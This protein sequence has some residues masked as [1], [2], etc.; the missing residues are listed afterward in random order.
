M[1]TKVSELKIMI[2]DWNAVDLHMHTF[3]G[4][5]GDGKPDV[6]KNF[7]YT[8]YIN[9]LSECKIKL[10]AITNHNIIN[11][12]NYIMCRY[13]AKKRG[14]NILFGVEI[15]TNRET[16]ENYHL[17]AIFEE[18]IDKCINIAKWINDKTN[19]KKKTKNQVRYSP[20]E[21][22]EL[23][24]K[25]NV[26]IIPHGEKSKGLF[27]YATEEQI[28]DALK[29]VREGFIRVFDSPSDWKLERIKELIKDGTINDVEDEFG[30]VLFSDNRDWKN[31]KAN[32]RNFYMNAEPT[33]KGFL[34]SIT[35][36]TQRFSVGNLIP[37]K[38]QY[39]SKIEIRKNEPDA[40]IDDCDIYLNSGYNCI[41]G[42]SGSGKS[43]LHFLIKKYIKGNSS[44]TNYAF[45]NKNTI[46]L[47]DENNTIIIPNKINIGI[48]DKIFN[49]IITASTTKDSSN[50]Y[51][52]IKILNKDFKP[53]TKFD[54]FVNEYKNRL[55]KYVSINIK[56]DNTIKS[57]ETDFNSFNSQNI[58][59]NKMKDVCTFSFDIPD[60]IEYTYSKDSISKIDE[61]YKAI[62][63]IKRN[64]SYFKEESKSIIKNK[65][66]ELENVYFDEMR[67]IYLQNYKEK[68]FNQKLN[69]V[70]ISLTNVNKGISSNARRK[71]EILNN[72]NNFIDSITQSILKIHLLKIAK[73]KFDLAIKIEDINLTGELIKENGITFTENIEQDL[74]KKLDIKS[75]S[76]FYTRGIQQ[77]LNSKIYDMSNFEEAK[78]VIDEYI[79]LEKMNEPEILK[80]FNDVKINVDVFFDDNNVKELNPGDISKKYIETYF[81]NELINGKNT[82]ILYDQIENDVD[83]PFISENLIPLIEDM[84]NKAQLI[85]ITHDPIV[86]VNADPINYVEATKNN[87]G[88]ITYRSFRPESYEKD[89]LSTIARCVDGSKS[90][91]KERYEIY[92]GDKTYAD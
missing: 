56:L 54:S 6:I 87:D 10:A 5:T 64:L 15:D 70:K 67:K 86:A 38:S 33:F 52:V 2:D 32:F 46:T 37:A 25:Y 69:I 66:N 68:L 23:I 41:I 17:V 76:I 71:T 22:V 4:I 49:K 91:I 77:M 51:D 75:N 62:N 14:I 45:S 58:E 28:R 82:I 19:E 59:L 72:M 7:T 73:K 57:L 13:L 92:K 40:K 29:K 27:K 63:S 48:G 50:M 16:G 24:R 31:Y 21:I 42:K 44:D 90:V 18:E 11:M 74:I 79:S 47:Y 55:R 78:K 88:I 81:K 1:I 36:P 35:N 80:V 3:V 12:T 30:G 60:N 53:K 65:V 89:E 39:I 20:D 83:K 84:K 61:I 43:L 9:A 8:N 85:I 26:V 34:H